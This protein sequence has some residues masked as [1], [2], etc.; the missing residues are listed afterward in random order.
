MPKFG[1]GTLVFGETGSEFDVSCNVNS[2]SIEASKNQGDSKTMLCGTT[3][4]G[5]VTYEWELS[6]NLDIDS[7]DPE[8]FFRFTQEHAGEQAPFLF[9]P[10]T[11]TET[12]A[13]G[14]AVI[15]PLSFGG[16][17]YGADMAS[18]VAY[19]VVGRPEYT[20][21]AA[22]PEQLA[23]GALDV[24]YG[25]ENVA[26]VTDATRAAVA[27]LTAKYAPGGGSTAPAPAPPS[28]SASSG[29]SDSE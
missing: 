6:G 10:N 22:A 24:R 18:D 9:V 13:A 28:S 20:Y 8:G 15:D 29:G 27:K 21:P 14:V 11:P 25:G 4:P 7:G 5:A 26:P 17:E 19:T 12:S 23:A 1:P 2:L 3:K 16:D